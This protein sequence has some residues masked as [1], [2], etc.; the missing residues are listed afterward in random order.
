MFKSARWRSE[1][2]K[3]KVVFKLQF[4]AAK[5]PQIGDDALIISVV[6]ADAGKPTVKSDKAVVRDGS[7]F[8]ENPV[9]ETVKFNREPKSG[10]IHERIY[11][12]VVVTGSSKAGVIGEASIDFSNYVDA[13]KVSLVS[14]PIKCSKTEATLHVSI[15][16][17]QESVDHREVEESENAKSN[18]KDHSLK[19]Q[20]SNGD[21]DE[22][23]KSNSDDVP[24]N[25][26]LSH[27]AE[28]NGTRRASSGSDITMSSS[29]SSSGV[30]MQINSALEISTDDS[31]ST[32][33]EAFLGQHLEESSDVVIEK[34][35]SEV[36]ALSRQAEM[37]ELE[38]Q[39]LRKQIVK[40]SKR[41]Q[42]L[43]KKLVCLKEER[44]GLKGECEKLKAAQ[45]RVVE[46]KARTNVQF[47]GGDSR[48]LVE[49]LRQELNHAK[50]LNANLQIQLQKTQES[51][52][53]L[54]LAVR[55]LDEMLEQKNKEITNLSSGLSANDDIDEKAREAGPTRRPDDDNDDEEQKALEELVKEHGDAKE[56]YLLEQQIIDMRSEI[57]IYKRDKDE[58]EMQMEQLALDYE[59]MKQENHEMAYKL[60][61]SELQEQLKL[62]YECS[63]SYTAAQELENQ[64][65]NLENELKRRSKESAD[66]LV[67]ISELEAHVKSLE[68]E[69]EKQSQGFEADLEVLMRS[70]VEQEQRAIR[71]EE[72]LRKTRRQN[73][74]TAER[75]QEE[76][77][78]LSVQM[79]STFESNE[80]LATKALAEANEL[81]LQKSNLEEM[82]RKAF[83]EHRSIKSHYE[84]RLRQMMNKMEKM[85]SEIEDRALE[86]E[87]Q[88]KHA[89]ETRGLL[90]DEISKLQDEIETSMAKN[91]ILS[92]EMGNKET[93]MN[94]LEQLRISIK[95]M[96]LLVKQ[97]DDERIELEKKIMSV[98][99]DAEESQKELNNMRC[100][101]EEKEL[102]VEKMQSKLDSLQSQYTELK[103]IL[104]EDAVEK[105]ELRKQVIL[106][107]CDLKKWEDDMETTSNTSVLVPQGSKEVSNLTE[108]IKSLE[109]QIKLKES[110]L[111][112]S[113]NAFLEKEKELHDEIGELE[114]RLEVLNQ[115]T[116]H[117]CENEVEKVT[118]LAED[119]DPNF[120]SSEE[121]RKHDEDSTNP[122]TRAAI[123]LSSN[124]TNSPETPKRSADKT[125]NLDE[126]T[127][128]MTLLKERNELMEAELKEMQERYSE[129]SV[130]FA[131]VEGERQQLVMR[132]RNLK[133]AKKRT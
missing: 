55:D 121:T 43:F 44:D 12:F 91:K 76:F 21:M 128:E 13:T 124:D 46:A 31:S 25:K 51:N 103:R 47:E 36:A 79:V 28:L 63:S 74:N 84:V 127:N 107:K 126:L 73:A 116:I 100:I 7:C 85:Q 71:A 97:G 113:N 52:S 132:V 130:K 65:E 98:K 108:R 29:E 58:L 131:E 23:I 30:E 54:I 35:K 111:E 70:K 68:E 14:L 112:T 96:E 45:R 18:Y 89:E 17:M 86:L 117:F 82:I 93:L 3:V 6:P 118:T 122:K 5:V 67:T 80:K 39:T 27:V 40:E 115:S 20:L 57:E 62:Q 9:Y 129:I 59:I 101:L 24:F 114:E 34:L 95:E 66:A 11:Y 123:S 19:A 90:S 41:G 50:E 104:S 125:G 16:R 4:H 83:E 49:E 64:I 33:R 105:D 48:E 94:E 120:R 26:T 2:N 72:T 22:S 87:N 99:C 109:D 37:S 32:P 56:A 10:K 75:L 88:K 133:N 119:Q 106:L 1:K 81:R 77:K 69:L 53:E 92:E 61:Q 110:A 102:I 38:L 60:E 78:R 15:Q 42:D 8:W